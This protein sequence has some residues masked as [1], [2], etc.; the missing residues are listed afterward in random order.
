MELIVDIERGQLKIPQFQRKFVWDLQHS[1]E[2]ID[3]IIKGYPIGTFI[4]WRTDERLR[5]IRNIGN[6][7]DFQEPKDGDLINYV[8]DGQQRIASIYAILKGKK[9]KIQK[10]NKEIDYS[11]IYIDLD[12]GEEEPIIITNITDKESNTYIKVVDL[13]KGTRKSLEPYP[14][15]Y[16]KKLEDYKLKLTSY[17]FSAISLKEASIDIATEVFT[18]LNVGGKSLTL[19]EIMV[20]KTYDSEK[21]FDL[22]EKY[23]ELIEEL[24]DCQYETISDA[25]VLQVVSIL[26]TKDKEAKECTRK[27]I[28]KLPKNEVI[29][30]WNDAVDAIHR[31][32]DYFRS[33]HNIPV[34]R[35]LPYNTLIVPFSYYFHKEK[36]KPTGDI[37]KRM[38]DMFWRISLGNRY[39]SGVESKIVQDIERIDQIL[40]GV[41]PEYD[42]GI[43]VSPSGIIK[44]GQFRVGTSYIK[45]ILSIM[46][47][48]HPKSFDDNSTVIIDN[49]HLKI[50][51]SKNYHHFFPKA[52]MKSKQSDVEAS[53][54]NNIV[55]ITIVDDFLN[56]R[57]I[58]ANPPSEYMAKFSKDNEDI[59][60]TMKTHLIGDLKTFGVFDNDFETFINK[61]AKLISK[62]IKKHLI[63]HESD[64]SDNPTYYEEDTD[65][66]D[67]DEN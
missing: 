25:T 1:A 40:S 50:A 55:N 16:D 11:L 29:E 28:L 8:L 5:S 13:L 42:W 48:I 2:L 35:M 36:K 20:A 67:T 56:K 53:L 54:V 17:D 61:R 41:L 39:S 52:Y 38:T 23:K 19:F 10:D 3:S 22:A 30:I 44:N 26:L 9:I 31:T 62:E 37:Q 12:A 66:E 43:K 14:E 4:F 24:K 7:E 59:A 57:V 51:T 60:S 27:R 64:T 47:S 6:I 15:K 33:F 34:S 49:S 18:R 46:A 45:A 58:K 21:E 63:E 32:I 65:D